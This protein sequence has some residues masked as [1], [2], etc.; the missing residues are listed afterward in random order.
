MKAYIYLIMTVLFLASCEKAE[1]LKYSHSANIF[2]QFNSGA[3]RDSMVY[4][5]AYRPTIPQD[6]VWLLVRLTGTRT[7]T[8]RYFTA[9]IEKDS[10]TAQEGLHY[11]P[12][13]EQYAIPADRGWTYIPF[14][15]YNKDKQLENRSV[16]AI[17]KLNPS[18]D[19]G[20]ENPSI[21]RAKVV[22]SSKLE[23]PSWW[24]MWLGGYY[25][26]TKHELFILTTGRTSLTTAGLDAPMNLYFT[27][28]LT[29][30]LNNPF[31]WVQKNPAKGYVLTPVNEGSTDSYY[32][33]NT[34][35]PARKMLLR[36]NNQINKYFF[37][38]ENGQEV[39]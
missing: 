23:K 7:A 15:V 20:I 6:T 31:N 1:E 17:I 22:F 38:D 37:I 11:E 25:S 14:V 30:M 19:F 39:N 8:D 12:L 5:F 13:K 10:S 21:I 16:S 4:T 18:E 9:R 33:Y 24:D 34:A 27:G 26:R 28:I 29:T 35:N 32:F 36:K 3:D 2:F